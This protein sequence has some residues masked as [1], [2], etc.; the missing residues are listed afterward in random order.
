ML[1]GYVFSFEVK[2]SI[3][4]LEKI[5]F[6]LPEEIADPLTEI[7]IERQVLAGDLVCQAIQVGLNVMVIGIASDR[8]FVKTI[9]SGWLQIGPAATMD[10]PEDILELLTIALV[11]RQWEREMLGVMIDAIKTAMRI[12]LAI[13]AEVDKASQAVKLN[14]DGKPK[15]QR[16]KKEGKNG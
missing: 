4:P 3:G 10:L 14:Q 11:P 2:G 9:T 1:V 15:I 7:A 5:N 6:Y 8:E 12:Y 13:Q 16:R